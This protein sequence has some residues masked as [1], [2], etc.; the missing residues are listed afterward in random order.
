MQKLANGTAHM[1]DMADFGR[2]SDDATTVFSDAELV[3][4]T[5]AGRSVAFGELYR[6]HAPA[7]WRV[8]QAVTGNSDDAYDAVADAFVRVFQVVS[9]GR[10]D[11]AAAFRPYLLTTARHAA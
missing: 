3:R 9:L 10:L 7:A 6:R 4:E 11:D 5:S 1:V 8:A 2:P